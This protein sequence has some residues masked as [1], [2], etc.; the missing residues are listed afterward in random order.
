MWRYNKCYVIIMLLLI[1]AGE[2]GKSCM[3]VSRSQAGL[4]GDSRTECV[5]EALRSGIT[6]L[7]AWKTVIAWTIIYVYNVGMIRL[8]WLKC[9]SLEMFSVYKCVM[10]HKWTFRSA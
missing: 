4:Q 3:G 2:T 7:C 10:Y 8:H 6:E 1:S 5:E 9:D